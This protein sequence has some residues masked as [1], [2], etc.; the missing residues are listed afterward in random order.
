MQ[1]ILKVCCGMR[2]ILKESGGMPDVCCYIKDNIIYFVASVLDPRVKGLFILD[3]AN[4][5]ESLDKVQQYIK[6]TYQS[7]TPTYMEILIS[8][9]N[10]LQLRVLCAIHKEAAL[11]SDVD[12]YLDSQV[13]I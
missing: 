7:I 13:A 10:S 2:V 6:E 5:K 9:Q 11:L 3:L 1:D 12:Q 4:R 8:E